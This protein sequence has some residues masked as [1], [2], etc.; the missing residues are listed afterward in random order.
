[1][2]AAWGRRSLVGLLRTAALAVERVALGDA[3]GPVE[4]LLQAGFAADEPGAYCPRCGRGVGPGEFVAGRCGGCRDVASLPWGGLVRLGP[5]E[6]A[7]REA[8]HELKFNRWHAVGR[9][10]GQALGAAVAERLERVAE[11]AGE[12]VQ[13][14]AGRSIV[15]AVPMSH[16]RRT[17]RGI[18]HA[19]CLARA[20]AEGAGLPYVC[21]MARRHRPAQTGLS[22][23]ARRR[24]LRGA[25]RPT[26][27]AAVFDRVRVV[28]VVDDVMTTGAT[29]AEACRC[30]RSA[31]RRG[32]AGRG[33][34]G[35][36]P[37]ILAACVA[38]RDVDRRG[39]P[40][41]AG[42]LVADPV[43]AGR[44]LGRGSRAAGG[45]MAA[46]PVGSGAVDRGDG[47]GGPKNVAN[48]E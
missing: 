38:V 10:L 2:A 44:A 11:A 32:P 28:V 30:L 25:M 35:P 42:V 12:P 47:A 4:A 8:I 9:Y 22:A 26:V 6:G 27:P 33:Q 20:V 43:E 24:N 19:T 16:W 29:F 45:A 34:D 21:T 36:E 5:Y 40:A 7:L 15:T 31:W 39:R 23:A 37:A 46:V 41:V 17:S 18:D 3:P 14:V 13:A 1:M 48:L